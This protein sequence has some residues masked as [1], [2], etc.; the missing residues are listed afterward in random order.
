MTPEEAILAF[1]YLNAKQF[2]PMHYGAFRLADDTAEQALS[3]LHQ[4]WDRLQLDK[5]QLKILSL[6]ETLHI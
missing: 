2:I 4:E 1:L 3:R 5:E 6:G